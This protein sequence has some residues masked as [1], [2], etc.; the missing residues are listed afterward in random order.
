MRSS[1]TTAQS[2][3]LCV[4]R[5]HGCL[6]SRTYQLSVVR[7]SH[8]AAQN[9]RNRGSEYPTPARVGNHRS[10]I[11]LKPE[12]LSTRAVQQIPHRSKNTQVEYKSSTCTDQSRLWS[13][14]GKEK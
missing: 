2:S 4:S 10:P 11:R 13:R 14:E 6:I 8:T 12:R 3:R 9:S 7:N 1:H 5:D